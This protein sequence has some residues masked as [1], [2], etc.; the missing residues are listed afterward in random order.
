MKER[1]PTHHRPDT[2]GSKTAILEEGMKL[3]VLF[4]GR[5]AMRAL[6][7]FLV[8]YHLGP[9]KYGAFVAALA[10]GTLLIPLAGLGTQQ[11]LLRE[12]ARSDTPEQ[13]LTRAVSVWA[14]T[15]PMLSLAGIAAG[16]FFLE[17]ANLAGI[18][19]LLFGEITSV[20]LADFLGRFEQSRGNALLL[21]KI[22]AGLVAVRLVAALAFFCAWEA[23][24]TGWML[25]YGLSGLVFAA[26]LLWR[27]R[28]EIGRIRPSWDRKM[29]RAGIPFAF[30]GLFVRTQGEM[31][32]PLLAR[33]ELASTG[34]LSVAQRFVDIVSLPLITFQEIFWPRFYRQSDR[35]GSPSF[36]LLVSLSMGVSL[37]ALVYLSTAVI[38][39]LLGKDYSGAVRIARMLAWLP[40]MQAIRNLLRIMAAGVYREGYINIAYSINLVV[41]IASNLLLVPRHGAAGAVICLYLSEASLI[42]TL[43]PVIGW[44]RNFIG[45]KG[46]DAGHDR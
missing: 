12:G 28:R 11:I 4:A 6:L 21:G 14:V 22:T 10:I 43:L 16:T 26:Y 38:P 46:G 34:N 32:K 24:L 29:A 44:Y 27:Y 37:A 2:G 33:A 41:V 15:V 25:V 20:S 1:K 5:T 8:A 18:S 23:H 40:T 30:A 17:G 13:W 45:H 36:F 3:F 19:V 9:E 42:V 7:I 31:N 35:R 39:Y